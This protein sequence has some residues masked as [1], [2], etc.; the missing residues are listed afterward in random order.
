MTTAP[1]PQRTVS[2]SL[3]VGVPAFPPAVR[4]AVTRALAGYGTLWAAGLLL[5]LAVEP[6]AWRAA[7]LGLAVPGGGLV[8]AGHAVWGLVAILGFVLSLFVWWA[9]GPTVLPPLV[10]AGTA[11]VGAATATGVSTDGATAVFVLP[12]V[13]LAAAIAL[14]VARHQ[15]QRAEGR[16]LNDRLA[17]VRFVVGGAPELASDYPVTEHTPED[18]TRLRYGLD[19]ALQPLERFDGF[20]HLDQFREG[21][22]RYQLNALSYGL[23]MSQFTRTPAFTG[24]LAE[25]QRNAITKML[26]RK[27]WGYWAIENAWGNCSLSRDPVDNRDNIMLTGFYGLMIGMYE[28]LNDD[29]FS[30]PGGLPFRWNDRTTYDH[31]FGGLAASIH[32]NMKRSDLTL[33]ACEPNWVY[34]VCNTFGLNT[35]LTHDRLHGTDYVDDIG[36][37]LR[38]AYETEFLRPDGRIIGVRSKHLGLS[39]NFWASPSVQ[40]ATTYWLNPGLPDIALRTWWL[41]RESS[42]DITDGRLVLPQGASGRLD[43]GNY[44][45]GRDTFGQAVTIMAGRE[46][47]DT[48]YVAA[49]ERTLAEREEIA[50]QDGA[51][52]VRDSSGLVNHYLNLGRFGRENG[53]RD[54]VN[55][56]APQAWRDGPRLTDAP[57]P[58]VL[59]AH[60]VSDGHA[61]DLVLYPGA[62]P[63][64]TE[65]TIDGLGPRREYAVSGADDDRLVSDETGRARLN[66]SLT[67]RTPVRVHPSASPCSGPR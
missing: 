34:T 52:R 45:L 13:L 18:L 63:A 14:H 39:W 53:L 58:E 38:R 20:T 64:R 47:G 6:V 17:R 59:V 65:L 42:L 61:L 37:D 21:A 25:A 55:H 57:Y 10:W 8:A 29:R 44:K 56:G 5:A 11:Y 40:L 3:P 16:R 23:S 51:A 2:L 43:P 60:A 22:L 62:G 27:S 15:V 35:L 50:E 30:Q 9:M 7:G 24:Y 4:R 19:L 1:A 67:G 41:L 33:F 54:L 12:P 28:S 46:I 49:A 26:H 32:R 66:V 31:E 48:E 36:D